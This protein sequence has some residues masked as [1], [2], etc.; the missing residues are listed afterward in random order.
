MNPFSTFLRSL[1]PGGLL[2][3]VTILITLTATHP[4]AAAQ[5]FTDDDW[6][7]LTSEAELGAVVFTSALDNDGNLYVGGNFNT[8]GGRTSPSMALA[9]LNGIPPLEISPL[10]DSVRVFFRDLDPGDYLIQRRDSFSGAGTWTTLATLP[11]D[12][13]GMIIFGD[14]NPP[15]FGAY[16]QALPVPD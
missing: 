14:E 4:K 1:S 7:S 5:T 3:A 10:D 9:Y 12:E 15:P 6:L 2:P 11:A 16:Y 13:N 8:A